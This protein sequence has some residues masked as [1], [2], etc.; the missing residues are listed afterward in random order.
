MSVGGGTRDVLGRGFGMFL[1][2]GNK[3]Y[4]DFGE[5]DNLELTSTE[6]FTKKYTMRTR[7]VRQRSNISKQTDVAGKMTLSTPVGE[8]MKKWFKSKLVEDIT[9]QAETLAP[10]DLTLFAN[11]WRNIDENA[12]EI[13][14]KAAATDVLILQKTGSTVTFDNA[15]NNVVLAAH[16][17]EVDDRVRFTSAGTLP[18]E[19]AV[20]TTY[21]VKD[22]QAGTFK[23]AASKNTPVIALTDDGTGVHTAF[24]EYEEDRDYQLTPENARTMVYCVPELEGGRIDTAAGDNGETVTVSCVFPELKQVSL[25]MLTQSDLRGTL[26]YIGDSPSGAMQ[27]WQAEV[28]LRPSGP[29]AFIGDD[30]QTFD[31][32]FDILQLDPKKP[33]GTYLD[34]AG[35][36]LPEAK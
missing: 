8:V 27:E 12:D 36:S 21:F 15:N 19:L 9:Q 24:I 5:M 16:G 13:V 31:L 32:E 26:L 18:A 11:G 3:S 10:Q 25:E 33:F 2:T 34:R 28:Q 17:F 14:G 35:L 7:N 22:A 6:E 20:D 23:V 30:V 1:P 29:I 4:G